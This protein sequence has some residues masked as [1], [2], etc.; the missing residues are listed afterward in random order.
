MYCPYY[1]M[2]CVNGLCTENINSCSQVDLKRL[3]SEGENLYP[4]GA[5]SSCKKY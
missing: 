5:P 4:I 2:E 3:A 1:I